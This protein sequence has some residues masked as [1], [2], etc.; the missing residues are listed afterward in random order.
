MMEITT[1]SIEKKVETHY[2]QN[3]DKYKFYEN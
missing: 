1:T 3:K 2:V